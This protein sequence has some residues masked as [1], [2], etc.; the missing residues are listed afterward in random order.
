MDLRPSSRPRSPTAGPAVVRRLL[1][2]DGVAVR[3]AY[4]TPETGVKSGTAFVVAHGFTGAWDRPDSR[5]VAAGLAGY[6][7]V[8][9]VDL[10][11]HGG[12]GGVTTLGDRE[13]LDVDAAVEY[14]RWLGHRQ[15][16]TVGFS[17]GGTVVLRQAALARGSAHSP[18]AVVSVSAAG[19][20][21]Y[22]GTA[23]MR[24]LHRAVDS[25]FGR[26]VLRHGFGTR[27]ISQPWAAPF[28]L[29]P[30]QAAGL[31]APTPLLVIHG[32]RD[33][34]FPL[35]H[36]QAILAAA[37]DGAHQRG[38]L[39]RTDYW[40]EPGFAHAESAA[41]A[42]LIARIGSWSEQA[43]SEPVSVLGNDPR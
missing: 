6:G 35:E 14:A 10:R 32:D 37:K 42:D 29:S 17:L 26:A 24:L 40:L 38:V 5:R 41:N 23:P 15:V 12:S 27:V 28:P 43:L 21:F 7:G 30:S 31:I 25:R 22:K 39:N 19:F 16:V 9:S 4:D 34:Y 33:A 13:V 8:V 1:A 2:A 36:P 11:G 3:V 20:W 18:D